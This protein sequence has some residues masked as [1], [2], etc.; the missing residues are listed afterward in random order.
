MNR[1]KFWFNTGL[2]TFSLVVGLM[3]GASNSP[4]IGVLVTGI[5]G[6]GMTLLGI[7]FEKKNKKTD[8]E[9][10]EDLAMSS[11]SLGVVGKAV[12][13]FSL[14]LFAGV[15]LGVLYR[16]YDAATGPSKFIWDKDNAPPTAYEAIDWV[17]VKEILLKKGFTEEQ[18][19]SLYDIRIAERI[20]NK[21]TQSNDSYSE[22][23][24]YSKIFQISVVEKKANRG[25]A[26]E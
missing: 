9:K 16:N 1:E 12:T 4:V 10:E 2:A 11:L 6:V 8:K 24:P 17:L 22:A 18:V 21:A 23:T 19:R 14:L 25:P 5:F 13:L 7:F 26:S 3:I 15:Y 20:A